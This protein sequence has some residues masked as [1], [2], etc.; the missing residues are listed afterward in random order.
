M[1]IEKSSKDVKGIVKLYIT[2]TACLC[3][4]MTLFLSIQI[5]LS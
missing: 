3:L 1:N 5:V 2:Q 4:L